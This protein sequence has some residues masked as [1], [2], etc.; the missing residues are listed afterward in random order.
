LNYI[1][2]TMHVV[3]CSMSCGMRRQCAVD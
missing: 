1:V 3:S 2:N